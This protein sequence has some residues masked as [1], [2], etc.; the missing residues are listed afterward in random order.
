MK[1]PKQNDF[2]YLDKDR[3]IYKQIFT[4]SVIPIL[5]HDMEMNILDANDSALALFG[6]EYD[7]LQKKVCLSY[8]PKQNCNTPMRYA[9]G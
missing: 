1:T 2:K 9:R 3:D 8:I 4:Y 5:V 7:E 6:Y